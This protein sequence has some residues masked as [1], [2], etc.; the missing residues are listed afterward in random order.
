M[1]YNQMNEYLKENKIY[2][3]VGMTALIF[4]SAFLISEDIQTVYVISIDVISWGIFS[5]LFVYH[6]LR[7]KK[8]HTIIE[9]LLEGLDKKYLLT[10]IIEFSQTLED[11]FYYQIMKECTKAMLDEIAREKIDRLEYKE[12]IEQWLHEIKNPLATIKLICDN[13]R[14]ATTTKILLE[15]TRMNNYMDQVLYYARSADVEKDY[16]I[17]EIQLSECVKKVLIK[18]K[19]LSI[20]NKAK[21]ILDECRDSVLTDEKWLE[22]IITQIINNSIQYKTDNSMELKIFTQKIDKDIELIIQDNG[23]GILKSDISRVFEKG[24]TGKN[25]RNNSTSTGLGLYLCKKLCNK[26]GV[27]IYIESQRGQ[28]TSVILVFQNRKILEMQ[29]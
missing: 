11:Q 19:R 15:I 20:E 2:I 17:K 4:L 7:R 23:I 22:F 29:S 6:Y 10:D 18:N 1:R 5:F 3:F 21:V 13:D 28:G 24:Y 9:K 12:Y 16:I 14:S 8:Y 27:D 25:G 26:L